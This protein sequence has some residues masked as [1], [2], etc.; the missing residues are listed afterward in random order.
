[1]LVDTK[2]LLF[3]TH[4]LTLLSWCLSFDLLVTNQTTRAIVLLEIVA[5]C[6]K[7]YRCGGRTVTD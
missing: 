5:N 6:L 1:M 4:S 3:L 2:F 7:M